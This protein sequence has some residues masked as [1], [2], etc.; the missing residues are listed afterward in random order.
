DPEPRDIALAAGDEAGGRTFQHDDNVVEAGLRCRLPAVVDGAED[1]DLGAGEARSY[2]DAAGGDVGLDRLA[3]GRL[4]RHGLRC[5]P[6]LRLNERNGTS[7]VAA[8]NWRTRGQIGLSAPLCLRDL[9]TDQQRQ[10]RHQDEGSQN[11]AHCM[12][13]GPHQWPPTTSLIEYGSPGG[14]S[15]LQPMRMQ[16]SRASPAS[17]KRNCSPF[18]F[19]P[20]AAP[21]W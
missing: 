13:V 11:T 8:G 17:R 1:D 7:G 6:L 15:R 2:G 19:W 9:G 20:A 21:N 16:T 12:P 5:R 18:S 4:R 14:A 10:R 3:R